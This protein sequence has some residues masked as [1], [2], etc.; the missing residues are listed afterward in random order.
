MIEAIIVDDEEHALSRLGNLLKTYC[1]EIKILAACSDIETAHQQ[2][3]TLKPQV[4]FL[5][6]QIYDSTG[7]E[8]LKRFRNI[9]FGVIFMTAYE[10]Y[11]VQAFRFSAVDYLLKPID[12]D[13]LVEAVKKLHELKTREKILENIELISENISNFRL[14]NKKITIPT[15]HGIEI[16]NVQ[17]IIRCQS[18][19][20]YTTLFLENGKS[21]MVAKTLKDFEKLLTSYNFFRVHNS[22]LVNL[23]FVKSYNKGKGGFLK[24]ENGAEIE[25]SVRRKEELLRKIAL[26]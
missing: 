10:R 14:R 19:I 16:L 11:A 15:L 12:P 7:F 4:V 1:P 5:D 17:E 2:I 21:L 18:E 20:N 8:L 24:L 26:M 22:H 6:V 23:S 13:E 3:N 9:D 25:V